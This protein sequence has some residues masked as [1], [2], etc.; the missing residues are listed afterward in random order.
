MRKRRQ[1]DLMLQ[2]ALDA[3]ETDEPYARWQC[4]DVEWSEPKW[5]N[6]DFP[7]NF[8]LE[9]LEFR[10]HPDAPPVAWHL[11]GISKKVEPKPDWKD[12]PDWANYLA[13][14]DSGYWTWFKSEPMAEGGEWFGSDWMPAPLRSTLLWHETLEERPNE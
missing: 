13:M 10:R 8:E 4:R 14:D 9:W 2:Y 1:A 3:M 11:L 6:M 5:M 12:A 7:A